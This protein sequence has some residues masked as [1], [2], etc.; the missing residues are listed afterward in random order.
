MRGHYFYFDRARARRMLV[1]S[2]GST[3]VLGLVL[4][5]V[6]LANVV[7]GVV[8][9]ASEPPVS[10]HQPHEL[11]VKFKDGTSP[12]RIEEINA[13]I[14]AT[15]KKE[16][17]S[18]RVWHLQLPDNAEVDKAILYYQSQAEVVYAEPNYAVRIDGQEKR[19]TGVE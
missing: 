11:L 17:K 14:G 9:P 19:G 16:F 4:C 12:E 7:E 15:V 5:S 18:I 8:P 13:G 1:R 3:T 2:L 6:A 10:R